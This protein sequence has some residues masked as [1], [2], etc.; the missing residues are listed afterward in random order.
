M[1]VHVARKLLVRPQSNGNLLAGGGK[2]QTESALPAVADGTTS[3]CHHE[4]TDA[5]QLIRRSMSAIFAFTCVADHLLWTSSTSRAVN[6]GAHLPAAH[7]F[8][9]YQ[10]ALHALHLQPSPALASSKSSITVA[11]HSFRVYR[12]VS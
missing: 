12:F 11:A 9:L 1:T 7:R 4:C 6:F 2:T 3:S 10:A 5:W 8:S